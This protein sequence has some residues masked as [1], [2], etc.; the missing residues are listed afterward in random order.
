MTPGTYNFPSHRRGDTFNG[1]SFE[2]SQNGSPVDFTDADIKIQFRTT[3]ESR[4]IIL[5]WSTGDG[6][7]TISGAGNNVIEM[8]AKTGEEMNV[9]P[10]TYKYDIQVVLANG[11]TNTYVK[12]AMKIVN[13]I[14]R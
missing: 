5:E 7:I 11:V 2:I 8:E 12:G 3:G 1:H 14:T 4:N 13:D 6:S 10:G 9:T